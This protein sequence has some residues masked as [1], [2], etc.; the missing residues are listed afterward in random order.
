MTNYGTKASGLRAIPEGNRIVCDG[1]KDP[2]CLDAI[3]G[4]HKHFGETEMLF[5]VLVKK[6]DC[7][8]IG[9]N[10]HHFG[11]GHVEIVGD[12]KPAL[13]S[14][15][16][17]DKNH[18]RSYAGEKDL[19]LGDLKAF[20]FCDANGFVFPRS[21]CQVT[22]RNLFVVHKE[23]SIPLDRTKKDPAGFLNGIENGSARIPDIHHYR[24]T[25]WKEIETSFEDFSGQLDFAFEGSDGTTFLG[26]VT[27]NGPGQTLGTRLE[28]GCHGTQ[29]A[30]GT[31]DTVMDTDSFDMLA[32][33]RATRIVEN[34]D[35]FWVARHFGQ[36]F[37]VFFFQTLGRFGGMLNEMMKP[38]G[39]LFQL[40]GN[41][42]D[43]TEFDQKNQSKK[44]DQKVLSLRLGQ[45]FQEMPKIGRNLFRELFSHG[46][47]ALRGLV[48]IGDFGRKPFCFQ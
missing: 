43:R 19:F 42:P 2:V 31:M 36:L 10:P 32:I 1:Q 12:E 40:R 46:F 5:D 7:E 26:L 37:L 47:R 44:I 14:S 25:F 15:E 33:S 41:F 29:A 13:S 34:H 27:P 39:I 18:H 35:R 23:K 6:L 22:R 28:N 8:A 11:L 45:N 9:V 16:F 48:S 21:L 30:N 4:A 20:L 3:P 38:L 24:Q 17:G